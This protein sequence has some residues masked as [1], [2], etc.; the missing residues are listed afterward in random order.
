[1]T[2]EELE[3]LRNVERHGCTSATPGCS[4][5][6]VTDGVAEYL[7]LRLRRAGLIETNGFREFE[8]SSRL[9]E[10]TAKGK[11]ALSPEPNE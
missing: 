6:V 7:D 3:G 8:R 10:L 4:K 1:M 2:E 9:W 5:V 11:R